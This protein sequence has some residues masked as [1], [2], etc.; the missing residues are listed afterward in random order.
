MYTDQTGA[1]PVKSFKG[2]VYVMVATQV[3]GNV[4]ISEP[5]KK[6]TSGEMIAAYRKVM[7]R[8][9]KAGIVV[10]KTHFG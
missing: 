4:I 3:D 2:N 1:F 7:R 6:K 9:R 8:F 10:K 5:M